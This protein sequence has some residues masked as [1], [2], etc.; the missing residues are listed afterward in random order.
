MV[1]RT[2]SNETAGGDS[3]SRRWSRYS[4]LWARLAFLVLLITAPVHAE[5]PKFD[6][7]LIVSVDVSGS[8]DA[9]RYRLQMDGIAA[10]L[11]DK[12]VIDT[13]LGGPRGGILLTLVAWSDGVQQLLPWIRVT[14]RDTAL[15]TAQRIRALPPIGGEFTC[16]GRMLGALA[17]GLVPEI[18]PQTL[19]V[20]IDVS[21]DGPDNCNS[22]ESVDA[23]RDE[24]VAAGAIVNGLPIIDG[25]QFRGA[26]PW[27]R[28]PGFPDM[29]PLGALGAA[30][31]E[32]G[33][34]DNWYRLHV[35]GGPGSFV[36]PADG[37]A[38]FGRA[39]RRKFVMEISSIHRPLRA[40]EPRRAAE[41]SSGRAAAR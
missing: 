30:S 33:S 3:A 17:G 10:A 14:S 18:K 22:A 34:L 41:M 38:D 16:L 4:V 15:E 13:I 7:A 1:P 9:V 26:M 5:E 32:F 36:L 37:Y 6:T 40:T 39:I 20:V 2:R 35:Q 11:E 28:A 23:A 25:E 8:V 31:P 21:G 27:F 24:A 12:E 19:R 29:G